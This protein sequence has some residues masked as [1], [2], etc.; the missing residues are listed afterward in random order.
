ML[1]QLQKR[2]S[3]DLKKLK[4]ELDDA[5]LRKHSKLSDQEPEFRFEG[6]KKQYRLNSDV[7][8]KIDKAKNTSD[9][10]SRTELLEEG[11]QLLLERNKHICLADKYGWDMV[12]CYAAEPLASDS[13]DE[14]R[15]NKAIK[16]SKQL[17][18][19]KRKVAAAKWKPKKSPLQHGIDGSKGVVV[20]K[21]QNF[22]TVGMSS[23]MARDPTQLCFRCS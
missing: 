22:R 23:N 9:D 1:L 5:K 18:E 21:S 3:K 12:E 14:K 8:D 4:E 7:L 20:E 16:E 2:Y 6:N 11:E 17:R 13:G 19:E 15:M 10:E